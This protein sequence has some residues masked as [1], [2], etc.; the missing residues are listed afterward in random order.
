LFGADDLLNIINQ[1]PSASNPTFGGDLAAHT[2][3]WRLQARYDNRLTDSTQLR[4]TAAYGR[5]WQDLG[6]GDRFIHT[7][8]SPFSARIELSQKFSE[9]VAANFGADLLFENFDLHQRRSPERRPGQP[10]LGPTDTAVSFS[11]SGLLSLPGFYTEWEFTPWQGTR[12]V[13]GFRSDYDSATR[14]WDLAPR[15]TLRQD[16]TSG[17]PRTTLKAGI[18]IYDQ[19]PTPVQTDPTYGQT[20]LVSNRS[21]HYDLGVEQELTPRI[22]VSVDG[23]YKAFSNQVVAGAGNSGQGDAYGIEAFIRYKDDGRFFGWLSYTL[24][25]SQRRDLASDPSRLFQYDQTQAFT[26]VGSFRLGAGWQLGGRFRWGSGFLYTP[27]AFGAFDA[28]AGSQ[29]PA[30]GYPPF[31]QRLPFFQ[32]LDLRIDKTWNFA[33][34][35]LTSYLDLQNAYAA[36]NAQGISYNY[37][38]TQSTYSRGLPVVPSFGLRG[39]F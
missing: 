1:S 5:D 29:M 14:R 2:R 10:D 22:D 24:S 4:V 12:I 26:L 38:F 30:A 33:G 23:F 39:E 32:Q 34:W 16:L 37:N 36:P 17:F 20:G 9:T 15:I 25:K 11:S 18:G 3:F 28:T 6:S 8:L 13:P 27:S 31:G 35:K 21:T 7:I 19:P